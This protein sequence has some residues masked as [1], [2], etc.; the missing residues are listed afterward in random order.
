MSE[1]ERLVDISRVPRAHIEALGELDEGQYAVLRAAFERARDRRERE[2][3]AAI[4]N[5]LTLVAA[6]L[7]PV[8]R[9]MLF[10]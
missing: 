7:R 3:N 1:I 4:D 10:T 6:L 5:G 9:R 2:L 8:A